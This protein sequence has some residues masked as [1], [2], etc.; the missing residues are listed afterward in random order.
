MQ[1]LQMAPAHPRVLTL[2]SA[3]GPTG[4][5]WTACGSPAPVAPDAGRSPGCLIGEGALC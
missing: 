5:G 4:I 2:V 1:A 3:A